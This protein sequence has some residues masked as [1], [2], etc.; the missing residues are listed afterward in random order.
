MSTEAFCIEEAAA[1]G[2]YIVWMTP[3]HRDRVY[4]TG[5]PIAYYPKSWWLQLNREL[6]SRPSTGCM[7]VDLVSR[8]L[9]DGRVS[10]YGFDFFKTRSWYQEAKR[11]NSPHQGDEEQYIRGLIPDRLKIY[12]RLTNRLVALIL[13]AVMT[14]WPSSG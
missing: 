13:T 12:P 7:A 6:K 9:G 5:I 1:A 8:V 11:T 14:A 3:K 2:D 10:L 4:R